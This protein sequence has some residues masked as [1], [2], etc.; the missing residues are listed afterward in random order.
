MT[1]RTADMVRENLE[2]L[3]ITGALGNGDRLDEVRLA[4]QFDVS[5][6]PVRE[7]LQML[8]ATG[9]VEHIPNRGTFVR[10]PDFP[11]MIEMFEVMAE[12]EAL[13]ARLA[14]RRI[15]T[16][17]LIK[18]QEAAAAC[19]NAL[20]HGTLDDYYLENERFHFLIYQAS[21]NGFLAAE[22]TRLQKRL[23]P[24]RL[25]Q[26]RVRGRMKQS[27]QEHREILAAIQAGDESLAAKALRGHVKIQGQ[28]FNDLMAS[29]TQNTAQAG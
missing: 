16:A 3:I 28:R 19:E 27:M 26:L 20:Q 12:L 10:H 14:A 8:T 9:L 4:A 23:K 29:Y 2:Q 13:C 11:E 17:Q 21:G 1:I 7:A 25:M 15:Q 18:M 6:T 5:R 24:F 22:A